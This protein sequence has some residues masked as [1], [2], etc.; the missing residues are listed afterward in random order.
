MSFQH[1]WF[2]WVVR[3]KYATDGRVQERESSSRQEMRSSVP[4]LLPM[5]SSVGL[6]VERSQTPV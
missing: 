5:I 4:S 3:R 1:V 6:A 2:G